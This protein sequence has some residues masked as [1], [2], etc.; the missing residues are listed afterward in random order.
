MKYNVELFE[1][2]LHQGWSKKVNRSELVIKDETNE[3]IYIIDLDR[4]VHW[5]YIRSKIVVRQVGA[6]EFIAAMVT[7]DGTRG[8]SRMG[9][10][11]CHLE[12]RNGK[13]R[14]LYRDYE[15]YFMCDNF[16]KSKLIFFTDKIL[17]FETERFITF[18]YLE[19]RKSNTSFFRIEKIEDT[20]EESIAGYIGIRDDGQGLLT[21]YYNPITR[22]PITPCYSKLRQ[23]NLVVSSIEEQIQVA[24]SDSVQAGF[25]RDYAESMHIMGFFEAKEE[26]LKR[27]NLEE[28]DSPKE[29]ECPFLDKIDLFSFCQYKIKT[30]K[31]QIIFMG[32]RNI[33]RV[34]ELG[35]RCKGV[36]QIGTR[37]FIIYHQDAE[38][39]RDCVSAIELGAV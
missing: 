29:I 3:D 25:A 6:N 4:Q 32:T 23:R 37:R 39:G 1:E 19:L 14:I 26:L 18:Y 11:W 33:I 10:C 36:K 35:G 30:T 16:R 8:I 22:S 17:L 27:G 31:N 15:D 13:T 24:R 7:E 5:P 28:I 38:S 34:I 20:S 12:L 9:L 2:G 21:G